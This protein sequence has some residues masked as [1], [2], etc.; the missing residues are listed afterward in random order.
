MTYA[1]SEFAA[2]VLIEAVDHYQ[3]C[4]DGLGAEFA[5]AVGEAVQHLM[6]HPEA[7]PRVWRGYRRCR[8]RR[9]PY[10]LVY[11]VAGEVIQ[12][13]AVMHLHREP[14]YWLP[15]TRSGDPPRS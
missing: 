5:V 9:F 15:R 6:D 3:A 12:I 13:I 2:E 8:V 4:R 1:F 10:G 14:E 7:C 11:T